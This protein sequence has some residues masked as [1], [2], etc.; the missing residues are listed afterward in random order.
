MPF[1]STAELTQVLIAYQRFFFAS[2]VRGGEGMMRKSPLVLVSLVIVGLLSAPTSVSAGV[3]E[4]TVAAEDGDGDVPFLYD[5]KTGLEWTKP[6]SSGMPI[7]DYGYVD[8][9]GYSLSQHVDTETGKNVYNYSMEVNGNLPQSIDDLPGGIKRIEWVMYMNLQPWNP[10]KTDDTT[11]DCPFMVNLTFDG[12]GYSACL[13]DYILIVG[14]V[15]ALLEHGVSG[16]NLW[17][18]WSAD[19]IDNLDFFYFEAATRIWW[20]GPDT[21]GMRL[22]DFTDL[23]AVEGQEWYDIPWY[24]L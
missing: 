2:V 7:A 12:V 14:P 21:Y 15:L 4:Q 19:Q 6:T 9:I 22:T 3:Y 18:R 17:I 20:G 11:V 8:M 5:S 1:L 24:S 23:N 10:A 16:S 13:V